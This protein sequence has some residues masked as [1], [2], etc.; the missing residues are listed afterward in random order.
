ME[1]GAAEFF[2]GDLGAA[3]LGTQGDIWDAQ[4]DMALAASGAV[5]A[6]A[7]TALVNWRARRDLARDWAD[8][9]KLRSSQR[10]G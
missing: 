6:M 1:W 4:K 5:I 8:S 10:G 9:L 2:G 3:Y 7:L